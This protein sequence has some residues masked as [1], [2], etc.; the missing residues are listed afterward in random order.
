MSH[1]VV[2]NLPLTSISQLRMT[3]TTTIEQ[4][5]CVTIDVLYNLMG[6]PVLGP[7]FVHAD[8]K[9]ARLISPS[10]DSSSVT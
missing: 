4:L 9:N 5:S 3:Y 7:N 2:K 1:Q 8:V 6:Q 10:F